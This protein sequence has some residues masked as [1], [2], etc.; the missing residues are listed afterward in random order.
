MRLRSN[1]GAADENVPP[2]VNATACFAETAGAGVCRG[3]YAPQ[4]LAEW[5]AWDAAHSSEVWNKVSNNIGMQ[6]N[7]VPK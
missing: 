2:A 4:L 6:N 3:A 5:R 1:A 7:L